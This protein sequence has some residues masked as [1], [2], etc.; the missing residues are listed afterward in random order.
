ML[1]LPAAPR[2][3]PSYRARLAHSPLCP[4]GGPPSPTGSAAGTPPSGSLARPRPRPP[5][6]PAAAAPSAG[7]AAAGR[8]PQHSR[9]RCR[10]GDPIGALGRARRRADPTTDMGW[11][12][13][14]SKLA[15]MMVMVIDNLVSPMISPR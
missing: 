6:P 10:R 4:V 13:L 7:P 3:P 1:R 15:V 5:P 11:P 8:V 12:D 9:S 2:D 14:L